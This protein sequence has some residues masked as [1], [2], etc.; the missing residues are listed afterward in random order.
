MAMNSVNIIGRIARDPE[1]R[2]SSQQ[3]AF[4]RLSV[5]IDRGKDKNGQ[6]RGAD[7]PSV[8]VFGKTAEIVERYAF[9]GQL[10][11]VSGRIQT[12]KYEKDGRTIYTTDIAA[13]RVQFLEWKDKDKGSE[14]PAEAAPV[15][16]FQQ[17]TD[18]DIPFD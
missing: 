16:G 14:A 18:D 11:A 5:A 15:E 3:V 9:K 4:G 10:I 8:T 2:Y 12:G 13:D 6:D 7:F 17:L 1:I